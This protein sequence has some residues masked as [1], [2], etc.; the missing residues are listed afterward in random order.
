MIQV[1]CC[2]QQALAVGAVAVTVVVVAVG[3]VEQPTH[4]FWMADWCEQ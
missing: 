1:E 2:Q 3:V 4:V